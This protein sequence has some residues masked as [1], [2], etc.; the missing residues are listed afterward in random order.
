MRAL[1][2]AC[3]PSGQPL[4][5]EGLLQALPDSRRKEPE[6]DY[7]EPKRRDEDIEAGV[8]LFAL[9]QLR[10]PLQQRRRVMDRAELLAVRDRFSTPLRGK[11]REARIRIEGFLRLQG[12]A[13]SP[14]RC[15]KARILCN[16]RVLAWQR[17]PIRINRWSQ[18][19]KAQARS[20]RRG[21]T[22]IP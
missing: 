5:H 10:G 13:D 16:E 18:T 11:G 17:P 4:S 12:C 9:R 1:P 3:E 20:V 7:R 21:V 14:S 8:E 15:R 22:G 6:P 2:P 19:G